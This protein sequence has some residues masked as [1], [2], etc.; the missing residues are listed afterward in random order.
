MKVLDQEQC[1]AMAVQLFSPM[2]SQG[3]LIARNR[4]VSQFNSN[5]RPHKHINGVLD[6]ISRIIIQLKSPERHDAAGH[7][8]SKAFGETP[9]SYDIF[10]ASPSEQRCTYCFSFFLTGFASW[11]NILILPC[12]SRWIVVAELTPRSHTGSGESAMVTM[13]QTTNT[14]LCFRFY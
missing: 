13:M 6:G 9:A 10:G 14:G 12:D 8:V 3:R 4:K 5:M 2:A 1:K 7:S 11:G